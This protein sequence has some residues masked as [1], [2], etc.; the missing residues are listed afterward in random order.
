[1]RAAI[2]LL[3]VTAC[4]RTP[5]RADYDAYQSVG[6]RPDNAA[7]ATPPPDL[8][9]SALAVGAKAPAIK[10][11]LP[12]HDLL[13]VFFYRG[14]WCAY[15]RAQLRELQAHAADFAARK[16]V[17][18]AI[19]V[20]SPETSEH[21]AEGEKLGFPLVADPGHRVVAAYGVFD[22]ETEIAWPSIFIVDAAGTIAWRWLAS[23]FKQRITTTEVL[24][25]IDG[26]AAPK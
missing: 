25:A 20:D 11:S 7:R 10:T 18:V 5:K 3:L 6:L 14:D 2:L 1:M 19:S 9:T 17:I 16:A 15:C 13:V 4:L 8:A 26:L 23:D 24:A 22:S 12:A 21:L